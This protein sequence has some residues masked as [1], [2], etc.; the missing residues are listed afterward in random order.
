MQRHA[1]TWVLLLSVAANACGGEPTDAARSAMVDLNRSFMTAHATANAHDLQTGGPIILLRD[2]Q[3]I[4]VHNGIHTAASIGTPEFDTYKTFAHIPVAVFMLLD[5]HTGAPLSP[6]VSQTVQ[7]YLSQLDD[8]H[9]QLAEIGLKGDALK[10][11]QRL[12]HASQLFLE[13]VM[14]QH[15]VSE[16]ELLTYTRSLTPLIEL[17]LEAAARSQINALH[18]QTMIWKQELSPAEWKQLRVAVQGAVLARDQSLALQYFERLL[19]VKGEGNRLVYMERY[20]PEEPLLNLLATRAVDQK[21][22]I[23]IFN[24]PERMFR[25]VLCDAAAAYLQELNFDQQK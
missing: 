11:Q 18:R 20:T 8:V 3:L 16:K 19:H 10:R 7:A 25:D 17:N 1:I 15:S 22:A 13:K 5:A 9:Q 21:I 4:L 2:G 14:A 12:L 6:E 24:D 23:A